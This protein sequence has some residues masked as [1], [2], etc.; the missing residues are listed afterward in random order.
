MKKID[1]MIANSDIKMCTC[2]AEELPVD[3]AYVSYV[4]LVTVPKPSD[5]SHLNW[6]PFDLEQLYIDV[7]SVR[8]MCVARD[9]TTIAMPEHRQKN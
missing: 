5:L 8:D 7:R 6:K 1:C 3:L 9:E 2:L 4:L